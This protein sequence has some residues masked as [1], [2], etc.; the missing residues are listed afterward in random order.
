MVVLPQRGLNDLRMGC[1]QTEQPKVG[2]IPDLLAAA[3]Q[4]NAPSLKCGGVVTFEEKRIALCHSHL[5]MDLRPLLDAE[6]DNLLSGHSQTTSD[7]MHSSTRRINPG[8]L[9]RASTFTVAVLDLTTGNRSFI[10][11]SD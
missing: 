7:S 6:P 3:E 4:H 8:T 5:T 11:V 10:K 1:T 9:F 2:V